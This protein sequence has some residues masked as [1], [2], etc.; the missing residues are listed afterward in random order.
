V[1]LT[2]LLLAIAL[3][4][5]AGCD[6]RPAGTPF[7]VPL[8]SGATLHLTAAPFDSAAHT[9]S[10][11]PGA[12]VYA[13]DGRPFFGSDASIPETVLT[14]AEFEA[15]GTRTPLDVRGMFNPWHEAPAPHD[16]QVESY[17][18]EGGWLVRGLFSDGAGSYAAEWLVVGDGSLR[19]VLT[20]N[21]LVIPVLL[22]WPSE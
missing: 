16:F 11:Y 13:I 5:P 22:R 7:E 18:I 2:R 12:G 10:R 20:N 19:T 15:G 6:T 4:S 9:L 21:D 14:S 8:G 17:G 3:L 1:Q